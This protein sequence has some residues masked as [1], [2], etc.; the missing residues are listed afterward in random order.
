MHAYFHLQNLQVHPQSEIMGNRFHIKLKF[1]EN[2]IKNSPT[3]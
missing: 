2:G 1:A 3:Y